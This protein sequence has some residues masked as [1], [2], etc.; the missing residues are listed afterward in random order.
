MSR[1]PASSPLGARA[2]AL[3]IA[4]PCT[5]L[6]LAI[7]AAGCD[8]IPFAPQSLVEKPR[9]LAISVDPPV[10]PIDLSDPEAGDTEV[11]LTALVVA[12]DGKDSGVDPERALAFDIRWRAC[13]PWWPVYEPSRDCPAD[14]ALA[15]E[16]VDGD[17]WQGQAK[18]DL[19]ALLAAFPPPDGPPTGEQPGGEMPGET[20]GQE[21]ELPCEYDYQYLSATVVVEID[22]DGRRLVGLQRLRVTDAEVS[23]R[24]PEIG[25]LMLGIDMHEPGESASYRPGAVQV[26]SVWM[27][28]ESL[29]PVCIDT[30]EGERKI[31][32]EPVD[33][34]AYVTA[35]E[36]DEDAGDI[37]YTNEI[38]DA[39]LLDWRAPSGGDA[40][41]WMVARDSDG[42]VSFARF[43][44]VPDED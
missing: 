42:G 2:R 39:D 31:V 9:I 26:M 20:P 32:E 30:L 22:I 17:T 43:P 21:E 11:T 18:L 36:L 10:V 37:F 41:V 40:A 24:S 1:S 33:F 16:A 8:E 12:P 25:G 14:E 15:L 29:D 23:R 6:A 35:G 44:L 27:D 19:R 13:N 7:A 28:R 34:R 3:R 5:V 38:E 4:L